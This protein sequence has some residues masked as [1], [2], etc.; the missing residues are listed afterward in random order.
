MSWAFFTVTNINFGKRW[1][2]ISDMLWYDGGQVHCIIF[3][4]DIVLVCMTQSKPNYNTG[5]LESFC[6]LSSKLG[7][8]QL[9]FV[10]IVVVK[11]SFLMA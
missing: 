11:V 4:D 9:Y 6:Q 1:N 3:N 8:I 2:L 10:H 5:D 7:F